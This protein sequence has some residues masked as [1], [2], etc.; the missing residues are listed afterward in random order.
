M[1]RERQT[2]VIR[3]TIV[4]ISAI[5][6]LLILLAIT[7][8]IPEIKN[9]MVADIVSFALILKLVFLIFVEVALIYLI[10]PLGDALANF[11]LNLASE[12]S[13]VIDEQAYKKIRIFS[14]R[15]VA[16]IM[17]P[18]MYVTLI[19]PLRNFAKLS[20]KFTWM[21]LTF[22]Y[23]I[24]AVVIIVFI[25]LLVSIGPFVESLRKKEELKSD[26]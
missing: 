16:F 23:I 6:L 2:K 25:M 5:A 26:K 18:I 3:N 21:P 15:L 22:I 24:I 17:I 9:T 12:S 19:S 4:G 8:N 14:K 10:F 20:D 7:S 1:Q 13:T 11:I